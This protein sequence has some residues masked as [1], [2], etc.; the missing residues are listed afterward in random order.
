[1]KEYDVKEPYPS[2]T[3]T[4]KY[5]EGMLCKKE[6]QAPYIIL[7]AVL[8]KVPENPDAAILG[9]IGAESPNLKIFGDRETPEQQKL[10]E[11][12]ARSAVEALRT[13]EISRPEKDKGKQVIYQYR[14]QFDPTTCKK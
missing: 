11:I 2:K 14:A 13:A 10:G 6:K 3:I 7:I 5:P 9:S 12:A 8:D 4:I 1:M